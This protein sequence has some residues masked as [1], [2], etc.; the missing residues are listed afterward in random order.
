MTDTVST[1]YKVVPKVYQVKLPSRRIQLFFASLS[2]T[3]LS[4]TTSLQDTKIIASI[5]CIWYNLKAT[6]NFVTV[7][8]KFDVI[9]SVINIVICDEILIELKAIATISKYNFHFYDVRLLQYDDHF[10]GS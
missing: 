7:S 3:G 2:F 1:K 10:S 6:S 9:E 5:K 8:V 4:D